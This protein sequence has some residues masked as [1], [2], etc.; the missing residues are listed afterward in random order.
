MKRRGFIKTGVLTMAAGASSNAVLGEIV[1]P[2]SE[3][4]SH[5]EMEDYISELDL[6]MDRISSSGGDY[7]KDLI[8]QTPAALQ[9][10][11]SIPQFR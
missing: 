6:R 8:Y 10:M 9:R 5:L 1:V 11:K 4:I 7:L 2:M 3:N